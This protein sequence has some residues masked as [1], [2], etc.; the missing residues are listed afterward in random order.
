[1]L[2]W[3]IGTRARAHAYT[4]LEVIKTGH[5]CLQNMCIKFQDKIPMLCGPLGPQE[6]WEA[7]ANKLLAKC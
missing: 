2:F 3:P 4:T 6:E 7:T 1:M 5:I